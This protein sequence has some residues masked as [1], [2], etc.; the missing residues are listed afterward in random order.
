[1]ECPYCEVGNLKNKR[2]DVYYTPAKILRV[3]KYDCDSCLETIIF[4]LLPP[5]SSR[6][7]EILQSRGDLQ[8]D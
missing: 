6:P 2:K 4:Q 8:L 3:F 7:S 5:N 1:M